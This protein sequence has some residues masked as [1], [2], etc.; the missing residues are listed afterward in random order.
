MP[1]VL[2]YEIAEVNNEEPCSPK[3]PGGIDKRFP[4]STPF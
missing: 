3:N 4:R 1:H 2:F